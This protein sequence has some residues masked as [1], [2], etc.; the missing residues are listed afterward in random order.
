MIEGH[1]EVPPY[2][3]FIMEEDTLDW[4]YIY[5]GLFM[6]QFSTDLVNRRWKVYLSFNC[7]IPSEEDLKT[8]KVLVFPGS[9]RAVHDER[10]AF[11]PV[12]SNFIRNVM[13]NYSD[14]K[15]FG[16]CFGH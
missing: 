9:A 8:I 6:G 3:G 1:F 2:Y 15:L 5:Q 16:S 7:E 14:I 4:Q 11:V 10:N 13:E 12:V